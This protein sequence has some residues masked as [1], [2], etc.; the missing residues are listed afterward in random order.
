MELW[1]IISV[2]GSIAFA[3]CG[4]PAAWEAIKD[5]GCNYSWGFLGLWLT[6]ELFTMAYVIHKQEW[7]LLFNYVFN[8]ACLLILLYFNKKGGTQS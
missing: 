4:I 7:V 8:L 6:G 5:R 3:A 1:W 2:I